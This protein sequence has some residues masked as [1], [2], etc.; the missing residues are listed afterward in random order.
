MNMQ[1]SKPG[2]DCHPSRQVGRAP[3]LWAFAP[4]L[5]LLFLAT[6]PASAQ[7]YLGAQPWP[8]DETMTCRAGVVTAHNLIPAVLANY[9]ERRD[10]T[11]D[12]YFAPVMCQ[13]L[14]KTYRLYAGGDVLTV[15]AVDCAAW[16]VGKW[17]QKLGYDWLGDLG[18]EDWPDGEALAPLAVVLCEVDK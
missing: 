8:E 18:R 17:P 9:P 5:V 16:S 12:G 6:M 11:A 3:W 4:A 1:S 14:G 7:E 13:D 10:A 15:R 2:G